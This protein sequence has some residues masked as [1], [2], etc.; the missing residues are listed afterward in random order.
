[1]RD[2]RGPLAALLLVAGYLAIL[3]W[4]QLWIAEGL[5]APVALAASP[6]LAIQLH[7]CVSGAPGAWASDRYQ[8]V[9]ADPSIDV[10]DITPHRARPPVCR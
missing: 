5:G 1:M 10:V 2:R 8:D 3:L 7:D 6:L 4:L 9:L